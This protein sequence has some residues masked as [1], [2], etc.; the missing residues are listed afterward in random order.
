[1]DETTINIIDALHGQQ[2]QLKRLIAQK[3]LISKAP[4][5]TLSEINVQVAQIK[6]LLAELEKNIQGQLQRGRKSPKAPKAS[7]S[8]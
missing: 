8:T 3:V 2:A 1:M 4:K 5:A 6:A 7:T